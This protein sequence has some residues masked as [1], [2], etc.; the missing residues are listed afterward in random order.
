MRGI[1]AEP[2]K[3]RLVDLLARFAEATDAHL[4]AEGGETT[5]EAEAEDREEHGL[6]RRAS[7]FKEQRKRKRK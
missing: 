2:R 6:E 7:L 1:D 4:I 3:Q 5:E